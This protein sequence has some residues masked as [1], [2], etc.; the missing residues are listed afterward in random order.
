MTS[1]LLGAFASSFA[2]AAAIIGILLATKLAA[3]I[4]MDIPN[5]RSL[6][7][8]PIPRIGGW[9]IFPAVIATTFLFKVANWP[10]LLSAAILFFVSYLDDRRSLPIS[11]R[12]SAQIVASVIWLASLSVPLPLLISC[13]AAVFIVWWINLFNFMDGANGLAGGTSL[14]GFFVYAVIATSHNMAPL[15]L[16]SIMLAGASGGFLLFNFHPARVFLGD[17]GSV[18]LGFFIGALG[19]WGWSDGAWPA[20]FPFMVFAPFFLDTTTTLIRRVMRGEQF[21]NAHAEHYYQ[22]L[23]RMGWSH[24]R[25]TLVGYAI[26]AL[27]AYLGVAMLR[28]STQAQYAGLFI[29]CSVFLAFA[30]VVDNYWVAFIG[31]R[32]H[33]SVR[34]IPPLSLRFAIPALLIAL[35]STAAGV[36]L[37]DKSS[38]PYLVVT[39]PSNTRI[40]YLHQSRASRLQC[41]ADIVKF[42]A[43][44]ESSCKEC[45]IVE[46]QCLDELQPRQLQYLTAFNLNEPSVRFADGVAVFQSPDPRLA[47]EACMEAERKALL[48]FGDELLK[49][50]LPEST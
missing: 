20:W 44:I 28:L 27:S 30:I 32:T 14:I 48:A 24:R 7:K 26:T 13:I 49:C 29:T 41:T 34:G 46:K 47:F 12:L 39:L 36:I 38:Y 8:R 43:A 19:V 35:A 25:V 4:A 2:I 22:R 16:W 37:Q 11:V 33:L 40:A 17:A 5:S 15:A 18:P 9:G 1:Q 3:R 21:W 45:V 23:V 50:R 10:L 42:I 6:H 31:K